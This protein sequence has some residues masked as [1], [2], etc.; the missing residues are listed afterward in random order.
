MIKRNDLSNANKYKRTSNNKIKKKVNYF[1]EQIALSIQCLTEKETGRLNTESQTKEIKVKK[2]NTSNN[3]TIKKIISLNTSI[4]SNSNASKNLN[5]KTV[6]NNENKKKNLVYKDLSSDCKYRKIQLKKSKEFK[7]LNNSSKKNKNSLYYLSN[8]NKKKGNIDTNNKM[9]N[10]DSLKLKGNRSKNNK[11]FKKR[12][13][14]LFDRDN[15]FINIKMLDNHKV[16]NNMNYSS[17]TK[18]AFDMN[19]NYFY[20]NDIFSPV[21]VNIKD[22]DKLNKNKNKGKIIKSVS[23]NKENKYLSNIQVKEDFKFSNSKKKEKGYLNINSYKPLYTYNNYQNFINENKL[24]QIGIKVPDKNN[25]SVNR[26]QDK[27]ITISIR[28]N[29]NENKSSLKKNKIKKIYYNISPKYFDN[30]FS[31]KNSIHHKRNIYRDTPIFNRF[32]K[33]IIETNRIKIDE[34]G[35]DSKFYLDDKKEVNNINKKYNQL[36][37]LIKSNWGNII[38]I[39]FNYIRLLDKDS[40]EIPII[41]PNY[42]TSKKYIS[43]YINGQTRKITMNYELKKYIKF[44]EIS[45]GLNDTGIKDLEIRNNKGN[46][47]WMGKVP[48]TNVSLNK[49]FIINLS[50]NIYKEKKKDSSV[51]KDN[52][53]KK[54]ET[55]IISLNYELC[56]GIKINFLDNYGNRKYIG[57][58]GI[59]IYDE[60]DN[61]INIEKN[62]LFIN[63]N[64][65]KGKIKE[66]P[67]FNKLFDENNSSTEIRNM[68]LLKKDNSFIEIKFIHFIKVKTI[69]IF[70]YNS[71][72]YKNCSTKLITIEFF[73]NQNILRTTRPIYLFMAPAEENI[74][75]GQYIVYPF[76][77]CFNCNKYKDFMKIVGDINCGSIFNEEYDYFSPFLPSGYIF[78]I[79]IMSNWGN[80]DFIGLNQIMLYDEN[81]NEIPL[82]S[83]NNNDDNDIFEFIKQK[84]NKLNHNN[85]FS[86]NKKDNNNYT[87]I[88]LLPGQNVVQPKE[89]PLFLINYKRMNH[90]YNTNG[91]NR[92]YFIFN[93]CTTLSK[94]TIINYNKFLNMAVKDIKILLDEKVIFE[95]EL[96]NSEPNHIYF[97]KDKNN[98]LKS[99]NNLHKKN[100]IYSK[101]N[102]DDEGNNIKKSNNS[103]YNEYIQP[104][105]KIL[106]L[107]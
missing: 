40:Q 92:L 69:K 104:N 54:K 24:H 46:I 21:K 30:Y 33:S 94:I 6:R 101:L 32:Y 60:N 14:S 51:I 100:Q 20:M 105:L 26:L 3:N 106:S 79:E 95:G 25:S 15:S 45:N 70:N 64:E 29:N 67:S 42:D 63:S 36:N 43:K 22:K 73:N 83:N 88:Y 13:L 28:N 56:N 23:S 53:T 103:R 38:I 85:D 17:N 18:N 16:K 57:L 91:E 58:S 50:Y 98:L 4:I 76:N 1:K 9:I 11:K 59:N 93:E 77:S 52:Q 8:N 66:N 84:I 65:V 74:D 2:S 90:I 81:N 80:N 78:K 61:I 96:K 27:S 102:N 86:K 12:S 72:I 31:V 87:R 62:C 34:I 44:I 48:K 99:I 35:K 71:K 49:S 82:S 89:I 10:Y 97:Y 19:D 37:F 39:S 41:K 107:K 5:Y 68:F 47:I 55:T 75:F 7:H